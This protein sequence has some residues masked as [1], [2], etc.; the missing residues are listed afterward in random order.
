MIIY[1]VIVQLTWKKGKMGAFKYQSY[2]YDIYKVSEGLW[3]LTYLNSCN[4]FLCLQPCK[5]R[6]LNWCCWPWRMVQPSPE[7]CWSCLWC[8]GWSHTSLRLPR[9]ALVMW[10]SSYTVRLALRWER[11]LGV[12]PTS[13][14]PDILLISFISRLAFVTTA[15]PTVFICH[16]PLCNIYLTPVLLFS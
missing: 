8:S 4:L 3:C 5:R 1:H 7:K 15:S 6:C 2:T 14:L 12:L 13:S 16:I 11:T 9:P 10:F